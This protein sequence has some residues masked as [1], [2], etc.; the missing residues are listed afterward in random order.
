[1]TPDAILALPA[2]ELPWQLYTAGLAPPTVQRA[3]H[4]CLVVTTHSYSS[5]LW[6]EEYWTPHLRW[7]HAAPLLN[8]HGVRMGTELDAH[9]RWIWEIAFYIDGWR[10]WH[11][12]RCTFAH[13]PET[14]C[15]LALLAHAATHTPEAP[16]HG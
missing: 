1:M 3:L 6:H 5:A 8:R 16:P 12:E 13:L 7:D 11:E 9:N 4:Q 15:R 14:I 2:E 10:R